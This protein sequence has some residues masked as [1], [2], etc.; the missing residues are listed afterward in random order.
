MHSH[1]S[2]YWSARTINET[3][4]FR[5]NIEVLVSYLPLSHIAANLAD[6]WC[7]F[8]GKGT[9]AFADKSALKGS[10]VQTLQEVR[11]TVF[12]AVPRV[13]E[14]IVEGIKAKNA[15]LTGV[16]KLMFKMFTNAGI[17]HHSEGTNRITYMIGKLIFYNK[18][19]AALGLDRCHNFFVAGAPTAI[20]TYQYLLGLDIVLH[21]AYGMSEGPIATIQCN[22]PKPGSSGNPIQGC[23]LKIE[24]K[25][26]QGNGEIC[27]WGRQVMMGYL[28]NECKTNETID[29][30][31]W[32]HSGDLG[33]LDDDN[34]LFITGA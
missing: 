30:N 8:L 13:Y 27:Y 16:K 2:V 19:L 15:E 18:L 6:V 26:N 21:D 20:Q 31:G 12:F 4:K 25:D 14:K 28:N 32:L 22:N 17:K 29:E 1:D 23:R 5:D 7:V 34:F 33:F 11:P 3:L 10:L 24:G 9:V